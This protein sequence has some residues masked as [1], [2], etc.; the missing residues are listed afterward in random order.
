MAKGEIDLH[1]LPHIS[2][3]K[4]V[5]FCLKRLLKW[6]D[7]FSLSIVFFRLRIEKR[8]VLTFLMRLK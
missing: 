2:G 5:I 7:H 3:P 1:I 4:L 8:L 6:L